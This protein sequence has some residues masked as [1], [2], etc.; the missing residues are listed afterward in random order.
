[1]AKRKEKIKPPSILAAEREQVRIRRKH[2]FPLAMDSFGRERVP[3]IMVDNKPVGPLTAESQRQYEESKTGIL[4]LKT[5][6][7]LKTITGLSDRQ[8]NAGFRF[9][10]D[11]EVAST[12]GIKPAS[13]DERVDSSGLP[14]GA[15]AHILDAFAA[16]GRAREA[17]GHHEIAM[18]VERVCGQR[19]SIREISDR[20]RDPRPA[21]A[22]LLAIGLDHLADHYF[23]K[24]K[25]Q[26][27]Q[28]S[29][30]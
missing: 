7:P 9:R 22:K 28:R 13:M 16:M 17:L 21:L 5:A 19:M 2:E 1:M 14:R 26:S 15:P 4:R 24:V 18:V 27:I 12:S 11:Y 20:T 23:G 30:R 25:A 6:D 10:A 29:V 3:Q 8:R